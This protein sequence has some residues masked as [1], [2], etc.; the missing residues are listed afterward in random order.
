MA[1][2]GTGPARF[3]TRRSLGSGAGMQPQVGR[4]LRSSTAVRNVVLLLAGLEL[5]P[6]R[7]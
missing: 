7:C 6:V 4:L 1:V 3:R 5:L 2:A